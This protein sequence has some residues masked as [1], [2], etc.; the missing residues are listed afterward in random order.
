MTRT[1]HRRC[2]VMGLSALLFGGCSTATIRDAL[3]VFEPR[4]AQPLAAFGFSHEGNNQPLDHSAFDTLLKKIVVVR[5]DGINRIAYARLSIPDRQ[6]LDAYIVSLRDVS[7]SLLNRR[8]QMA[9]WVNLHNALVIRIIVTFYPVKTIYEA[10]LDRDE[11][12]IAVEG[13]PVSLADIRDRVIRATARTQGYSTPWQR[14][15]NRTRPS[16]PAP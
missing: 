7:V 16:S 9:F 2:F 11:K 3:P 5:A 6:A 13:T 12:V 1:V 15:P 14:G 8:E 10:G 4:P